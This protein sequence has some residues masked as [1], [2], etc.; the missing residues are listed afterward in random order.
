MNS[1]KANK[2]MN[3]SFPRKKNRHLNRKCRRMLPWD[4]P[5]FRRVLRGFRPELIL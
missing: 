2:L 5:E 4:F 3:L 1:A